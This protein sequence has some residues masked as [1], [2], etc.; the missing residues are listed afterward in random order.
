MSNIIEVKELNKIYKLY[1]NK[2]DRLK[3]ALNFFLKKKKYHKDFYALN[4]INLSVR[5]GE[6]VG[7]LGKNGA[8][9]STLLKVITGV[10]T[11]S[12]GTLDI[13][14]KISALIE[15]G[16]GFNPEY[17]GRE[18]I[19][20]YGTLMGYSKEEMNNKISDIIKFADIG[21]FIEQPVKVYS[22]GMFARLAFSCSINVNPDILI[23]DEILAVGDMRF[24]MK[25]IT[26]MKEMMK[27]GVTILF[28]SHD[29][30]TIKRFCTRAVW[31]KDGKVEL[32][33]DINYVTDRYLDFLKFEEATQG[34]ETQEEIEKNIEEINVRN[35]AEIKSFKMLSIDGIE[36][37]KFRKY[38]VLKVEVTYEVYDEDIEDPVL[39]VA[40]KS[41][42][43]KYICGLNTLLDKKEI[44]WKK[45]ENKYYLTYEMG[46]LV[47]GGM[48][49]FDC[50][51]FESTAT[52][53]IQ[54]ISKVKEFMIESN[55]DGEGTFMI[56][57]KW[58]EDSRLG[59][60]LGD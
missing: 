47:F 58:S 13:E 25:C 38:D 51:L 29:I 54:Y 39:G 33:G 10:L 56:P 44:P 55:Y 3:E 2:K 31:L 16:A 14:G 21:D 48:Y 27:K 30:N 40:I 24:Q 57:H 19:Y 17:T 11:Q 15:L 26:K 42:D 45:G 43:N 1:D 49:Y 22:S 41:I 60:S 53:P 4:N 36:K 59:N 23:V 35:I 18:N 7:L 52:V 9:K 20:L 8:G 32:D 5:K 12:S 6:I 34:M 37:E 28:V 46:V 50:A